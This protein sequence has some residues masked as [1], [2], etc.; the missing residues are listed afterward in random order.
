MIVIVKKSNQYMRPTGPVFAYTVNSNAASEADR[1]KELKEYEEALGEYLRKNDAGDLLHFS[2]QPL[3][4]G[5]TLTKT[6]K[7]RYI[8]AQDLEK[9]ATEAEAAAKS[10][11]AKFAGMKAALGMTNEEII[12]AVMAA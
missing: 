8:V 9:V 1:K 6:Q 12:K 11:E 3:D 7:G 4:E 2:R 5:T 10:W